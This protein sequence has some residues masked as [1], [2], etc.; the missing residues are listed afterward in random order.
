M[1]P[2]IACSLGIAFLVVVFLAYDTITTRRRRRRERAAMLAYYG[3]WDD[4]AFPPLKAKQ[5]WQLLD[6]E[7]T[8]LKEE[9]NGHG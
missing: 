1:V 6:D 8:V 4:T 2:L 3:A 5:T 9:V 7:W